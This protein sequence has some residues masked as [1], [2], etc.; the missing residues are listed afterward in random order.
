MYLLSKEKLSFMCICQWGEDELYMYLLNDEKLSISKGRRNFFC[1]F[2][3][4]EG[5]VVLYLLSE[6]LRRFVQ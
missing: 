5:Y 4:K 1:D 2:L 3:V 6:F